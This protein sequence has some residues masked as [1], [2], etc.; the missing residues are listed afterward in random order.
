[1]SCISPF[2]G[3]GLSYDKLARQSARTCSLFRSVVAS[4]YVAA[5]TCRSPKISS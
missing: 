3:V 4:L 5:G 1:M 2:P